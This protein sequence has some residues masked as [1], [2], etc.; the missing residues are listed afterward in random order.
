ML[1]FNDAAAL[2]TAARSVTNNGIDIDD[3]T[4]AIISDHAASSMLEKGN[5]NK[6][7]TKMGLTI[8]HSNEIV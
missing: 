8:C 5:C 1:A 6:N 2:V 3:P 4:A 7:G